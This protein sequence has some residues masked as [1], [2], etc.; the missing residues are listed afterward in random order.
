LWAQTKRISGIITDKNGKPVSGASV[1][2]KG[3]TV[4]TITGT[5]GSYVLNVP[6]TGK[7]LLVSS[8]NFETQE[9][10]IGAKTTVTVSLTAADA[11][12]EE[13]VVVGYGQRKKAGEVTGAV[14]KVAGS[15]VAE[16]P[17]P[18]FDAALSGKTA[19]VQITQT[20]GLLGDGVA[21]R[22]RG[23]NSISL[24]SQPLVVIDG[25]PQISTTNLNSFNGGDGT[26]FNPFA[27]VN[28]NDIESIEVL[29]D[30]GAA[31]IYGSRASNG[32][33]LI[34]TK[35]GKKGTGKVGVDV[36]YGSSRAAS[37][38]SL[39][40]GDQ[41]TEIS[42][43]KARNRYGAASPN[44]V[45]ARN[46]DLDG[47]GSPDRTN[48]LDKLYVNGLSA[49]YG[50]NMSGGSEKGNY[51]ASVRYAKQDGIT[52]GNSLTTGQGRINL[53]V[54]PKTWF[55]SGV[56]LSYTKSLNRGVLSDR[57][58]AGTVTSG[59][60]A[61][62]NVPIYM[63]TGALGYNV[64]TASPVGLLNWGNNTR[65]VNGVIMFPFNFYNPVAV[66]DLQRN[67][68]T[69]EDLRA[70]SYA[71]IKFL[72]GFSITSKIGIQQ[73]RNWED[74]Y[75]H[76]AIAGLG[77]PYNGL[78]QNNELR[79]SS[80]D[81]QNYMTYDKTFAGKHKVTFVGGM[82][83]QRT[84]SQSFYTGAANF[85][86]PFFTGIY[87]GTYSNVQP[88][89]T[90]TLNLTGGGKSS[91]GLESYFSRLSYSFAGKY[92]VEG[93]FRRDAYS[94]FGANFKWGN[95]SSV[96]AGWD[97]TK[98]KFMGKVSWIDLL[99]IRGSWGEVG[100]YRG[101]GAYESRGL[102]GGALYTTTT[103]LGLSQP[104]NASI[105]WEKSIKTD[106]GL[107]A[108]LFKGKL[109]IVVDY[110]KN[111][112]KD[113]ILGAP[114]LHT[115]GVPGSTINKNI[116]GMQNTGLEISL[117]GTI[118]RQKDFT[119]TASAN[120]TKI[121]NNVNGLVPENNNADI[122]AAPSV[123]SVGRSLGTFWMPIWA[124]VDPATGNPQWFAANGTIK[125]YN[126]STTG[127]AVGTWTDDKGAPVA[128]VGIADNK[129]I[130]GKQGLPKWYGGF[131][132]TF[133]YKNID[134]SISALFQGGNWIYN[135]TRAGVFLNNLFGNNGTE[136]LGRWQKPGDVTDVPK[137]YLQ[138]NTANQ[139][140]TRFLEKGDFLRIR[141]ISLAYRLPRVALD[142]IG[143]E[144]IR[145]YGQ[146]FNPFT[147]TKYSGADPEVNTNRFNNIA[148]GVDLRNV[149][150]PRTFTFG[151]QANF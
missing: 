102:Y 43:E 92:F 117:N 76:P 30:A 140:S 1:L 42:N 41:F 18:S 135:S 35:R 123:A 144:N 9:V 122:N 57:Y 116:G 94:G 146:V 125:R 25:I 85:S 28:S 71:E 22:I 12:L 16:I 133:S 26:R 39:L 119:W 62:P 64:T 106:I 114:I 98:E 65:T 115:V 132:N 110:F 31:V 47:D 107:E 83:Y 14:S 7:T 55:K 32:V 129:Y 86:D 40:N 3:T 79:L 88:G 80:W 53:E 118:I 89:T 73:L 113:L 137:L 111:N 23:I 131:D 44:A 54:T 50:V 91:D 63:P 139:L 10:S 126:Y 59:W 13:V 20:G 87:D 4:G 45:I 147:F 67:N 66:V 37:L 136:I 69:A 49:D 121:K 145:I 2:V 74:Q 36:K 6:T 99:K 70:N 38:P 24:S 27:L 150:Q 105:R 143:F 56:E 58:L 34:T 61:L 127:G 138:D 151:I 134:L 93:S 11:N 148:I 96:S 142:K 112:I 97:I 51:F 141:T 60:Q 5:D 72:K 109:G 100:N 68:N 8:T 46:S 19:G 75:S 81:W 21:I 95:F 149:P 77:N 78:V 130:D 48:W 84:A 82:E 52:Y 103:G 124:G 108:T 120:W 33:I 104:S 90:V 101:L 29:K 17:L 15:K 128:P